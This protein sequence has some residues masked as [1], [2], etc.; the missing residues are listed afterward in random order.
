MS[1]FRS[2][3]DSAFIIQYDQGQKA[4]C[5]RVCGLIIQAFMSLM[6]RR[7]CENDNRGLEFGYIVLLYHHQL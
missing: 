2:A 6:R 1:T 4:T 7:R 5:V 3:A